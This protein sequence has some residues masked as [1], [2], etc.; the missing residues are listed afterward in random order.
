MACRSETECRLRSYRMRPRAGPITGLQRR[1]HGAGSEL[2]RQRRP[3][4]ALSARRGFSMSARAVIL[5]ASAEGGRVYRRMD[6]RTFARY[7]WYVS[8]R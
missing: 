5:Q 1:T 7:P 2:L 8:I 4:V 6:F 3:G